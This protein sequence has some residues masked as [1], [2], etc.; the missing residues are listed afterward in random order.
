MYLLYNIMQYMHILVFVLFY[1]FINGNFIAAMPV[2]SCIE[3][4]TI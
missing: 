1:F 2:H 4:I 3:Q